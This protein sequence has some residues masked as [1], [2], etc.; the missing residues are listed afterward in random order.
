MSKEDYK[1]KVSADQ[2]K[3]I[4]ANFVDAC[5]ARQKAMA[6]ANL[7]FV[8]ESRAPQYYFV[9]GKSLY[10]YFCGLDK[11]ALLELLQTAC[12]NN[13]LSWVD[14]ENAI[15][16]G[17]D[18]G[19]KFLETIKNWDDVRKNK[20]ENEKEFSDINPFIDALITSN[21]ILPRLYQSVLPEGQTLVDDTGKLDAIGLSINTEWITESL[22][23]K[24]VTPDKIQALRKFFSQGLLDSL[25]LPP[26]GLK[27]SLVLQHVTLAAVME[28]VTIDLD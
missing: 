2:L 24:T 3:V 12:E 17:N 4:Q 20:V 9:N 13:E 25:G 21:N 8:K 18:N 7:L 19:Q 22:K 27:D 10:D 11:D 23:P 5:N 28:K 14:I 6:S 1:F 26:Q 16:K 15:P